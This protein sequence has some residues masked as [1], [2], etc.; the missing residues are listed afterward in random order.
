MPS[1]RVAWMMPLDGLTKQERY[2][3]K[4]LSLGLCQRCTREREDK[5]K[6]FCSVCLEKFRERYYRLRS[7]DE[8]G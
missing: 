1:G 5:A 7:L 8:T 2:K 3:L 4:K 6:G